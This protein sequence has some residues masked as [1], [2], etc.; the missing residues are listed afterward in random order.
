MCSE[1]AGEPTARDLLHGDR[2]KM[3]A[4]PFGPVV[5]ETGA[6]MLL[7][8][9]LSQLARVSRYENAPAG[10]GPVDLE[11]DASADHRSVQFGS[12]VGSENDVVI[13]DRV[14]HGKDH[15][16]VGDLH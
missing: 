11:G 5:P 10:S 14:V 3:I 12:G 1:W 16:L 8:F 4:F 2:D 9:Q 15:E 6:S 13:H 7:L